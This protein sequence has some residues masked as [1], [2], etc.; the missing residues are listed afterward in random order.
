MT[1]RK[2]DL[3]CL[4][5]FHSAKILYLFSIA[6]FMFSCSPKAPLT[7]R[8]FMQTGGATVEL[9]YSPGSNKAFTVTEN[10]GFKENEV[11]NNSNSQNDAQGDDIWK[12][13]ELDKVDIVAQRKQI[14]RI[15]ERNG[16]VSIMFYVKA[17]RVLLD[18]CWKLT[19]HPVLLDRDTSITLS[20]VIIRG[21]E[22]IKTQEK[23]Y[24]AYDDFL[25]GI[26]SKEKYDSAFIDIK[27]IRRD[28]YNRQ[29]LFLK[30]YKA[31]RRKRLAYLRWKTL[32]DK[33]HAW[34]TIK[35]D[36]N[37]NSL[38]QS[39]QRNSLEESVKQHIAG[40]DT[41]GVRSSY[42]KKYERR[43]GFWPAYRFPKEMTVKDVPARYQALYLSGGRLEDIRN[44]NLTPKDSAEIASLRY[45]KRAIAENEYNSNNRDLIRDR[46]IRLPYADSAKIDQVANPLEDFAY[47]YKYDVP[48]KDGMK[49]LNI[50][51]HG[52]VLAMDY[53][54]WTLPP[55]DTLT[56]VIASVADLTDPQLINRFN[57][58]NDSIQQLTPEGEE[59]KQG[60]E[61]LSNREYKKAI[62][63]LDKYPDYNTAIALTCLGHHL[64]A[65]NLLKQLP[66]TA[67]VKYLRSI[68][69]IRLADY[70]TAVDLLL[71]ACREEP[72]LVYRTDMDSDMSILIPKVMGLRKELD[73]IALEQ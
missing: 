67:A 47:L 21:K 46:I 39:M 51:L 40:N 68:V 66:Q 42:K 37:R 50:T 8:L 53:S 49:K 23:Q 54:T 18:S 30:V 5:R 9:P 56:F 31:E 4:K 45:F 35:V 28:I 16:Q 3:Q 69:N 73:R 71:E 38:K 12:S 15:M 10:V 24:Q 72:N 17:P 32:A 61:A 26:V 44:Y 36:G 29:K 25:N 57:I 59:Y 2:R 20:P 64:N 62:A 58:G 52:K 33:R 43:T 7:M 55:A 34:T 63:I 13:V 27:G 60:M 65:E 1:F 48:V 19:L 22:F 70:Q 11:N 14:E 41:V 6:C